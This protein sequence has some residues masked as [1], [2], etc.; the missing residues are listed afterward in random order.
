MM[1]ERTEVAIVGAGPA[2]LAV[3]AC[4]ARAGVP[5]IILERNAAV[6][7]SWRRHYAR[8]HLHTI[9]QLSALPYLPFAAEEPRY[10]SRDRVIA[11]LERYAAEFGLKPRFGETVRAVRRDTDGWRLESTNLSLHARHVVVASGLNAEPVRPDIAGL[12][13]F[14][15][16][17]LHSGD[18]LSAAPFAGQSVLV[19]GMGNTGAEIAL[20]LA[21]ARARPTLS[22]RGGV[23]TAPRDLFGIPI[24]RVALAT[25]WLPRA[26][27]DTIFPV[28]L[29]AALGWPQRHG[30]RR[31]AQGL[32]EQIALAGKIPVLD[33]GTMRNIAEGK[34]AIV[35]GIKTLTEDG[36]VFT[37]GRMARFDAIVLATGF[38][39]NYRDFL[40]ADVTPASEASVQ[41]LHFVGFRSPVTGLL[42]EISREA[43][44]VAARIAASRG[45][46][47]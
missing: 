8:L 30:I 46:P 23:H 25:A 14:P 9:K 38:R 32:L 26:L 36:A 28:I 15:G 13:R 11:Y 22:L 16:R 5:F 33:V 35:P 31:P 10:V 19:I 40:D 18:Y 2:G 17:V 27:L 7:S 34:I 43:I 47:S 39:P 42:R 37:N 21:E 45:A 1:P 20:D 41:G 6:G 3:A 12:D 4:L 24:Q 29:D 44:A